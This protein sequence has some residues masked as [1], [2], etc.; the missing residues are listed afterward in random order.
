M[1]ELKVTVKCEDW[2]GRGGASPA[3]LIG[4][5]EGWWCCGGQTMSV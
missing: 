5:E 4:L 3:P 2:T 1:V